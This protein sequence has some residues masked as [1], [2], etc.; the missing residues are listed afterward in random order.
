MASFYY[1]RQALGLFR[2]CNNV[3]G[4][5]TRDFEFDLNFL[6][7]NLLPPKTPM[8]RDIN[9]TRFRYVTR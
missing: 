2:C 4:L 1:S 5:P 9:V 8:F 6:N 7:P 3:Y